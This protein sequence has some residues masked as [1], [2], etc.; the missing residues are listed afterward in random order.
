MENNN[1]N[2]IINNEKLVYLVIKDLKMLHLVDMYYDIG[3]IGLIKACRTYDEK[4]G[5]T[6]STYA[7]KVIKREILKEIKKENCEKRKSMKN[8]ISLNTI[9][10]FENNEEITLED[11]IASDFNLEEEIIKREEIERLYNIIAT[12]TKKEQEVITRFYGLG[13]ER[14]KI[15]DIAE[16]LGLCKGTIMQ[17]KERALNKLKY[18][19]MNYDESLLRYSRSR[20]NNDRGRHCM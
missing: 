16:E 11:K 13:R 8:I 3:I 7:Y 1:D 17:R 9:L 6:F 10:N 14:M 15:S 19:L 12:L 4:K 5:Y 20:N 18:R 2:L